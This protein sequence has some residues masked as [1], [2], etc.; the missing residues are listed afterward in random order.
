MTDTRLYRPSS[1]TEGADFIEHFCERCLRDAK[2]RET[3]DGAD[4]CDILRRS[5]LHSTEEPEY[6]SEWNYGED[7]LPTCTAFE[8]EP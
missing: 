8:A 1:G 7:G 4:S 3:D 6:P 5:F 2:Y